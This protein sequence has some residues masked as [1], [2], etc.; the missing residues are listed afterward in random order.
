MWSVENGMLMTRE[1]EEAFRE[2]TFV[3]VPVEKPGEPDGWKLVLI[4][5]GM[6]HEMANA[7]QIWDELD[8]VEL[9]F[10]NQSRPGRAFVYFAYCMALWRTMQGTRRLEWAAL[11]ERIESRELWTVPGRYLRMSMFRD[12][13]GLIGDGVVLPEAILQDGDM[14]SEGEVP[15]ENVKDLASALLNGAEFDED[16]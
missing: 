16:G 6:R 7:S 5:E 13:A 9:E 12:L 3:L 1:L 4:D 2:G 10:R 11:K 8:G 14:K 15:I